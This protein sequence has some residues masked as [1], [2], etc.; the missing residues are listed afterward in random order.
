MF[1]VVLLVVMAILFT[2]MISAA[3]LDADRYS[4]RTIIFIS[5]LVLS[6]SFWLISKLYYL[7]CEKEAA[8]LA[9]KNTCKDQ[10]KDNKII[11]CMNNEN[12]I[13]NIAFEKFGFPAKEEY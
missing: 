11:L 8:D 9:E 1:L 6:T 10:C 7:D 2:G 4:I 12:K 13:L 5:L 3:L